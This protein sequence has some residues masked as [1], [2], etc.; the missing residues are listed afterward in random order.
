MLCLCLEKGMVDGY[1]L[2]EVQVISDQSV[3]PPANT[4]QNIRPLRLFTGNSLVSR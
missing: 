3:H 4:C 2:L 1:R